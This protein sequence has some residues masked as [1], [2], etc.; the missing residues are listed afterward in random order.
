MKQEQWKET[1]GK[2]SRKGIILYY[3]KRLSVN[4]IKGS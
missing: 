3:V 2:N 1:Y 4:E